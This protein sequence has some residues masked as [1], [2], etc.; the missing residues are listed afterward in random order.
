LPANE[1]VLYSIDF[2]LAGCHCSQNWPSGAFS[3]ALKSSK[4]INRVGYDLAVPGNH[5][6]DFG[7]ALAECAEALDRSYTSIRYTLKLQMSPTSTFRATQIRCSTS[8]RTASLAR[9][10]R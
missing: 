2:V 1:L 7:D 3:R 9:S 10:F 4:M 6:F 5:D 8:I